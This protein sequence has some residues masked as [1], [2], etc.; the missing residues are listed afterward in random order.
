MASLRPYNAWVA[1][2]Y[3]N[4]SPTPSTLNKRVDIWKRQEI[5]NELG[6]TAYTDFYVRTVWAQI[7][8]QTGSMVFQQ[9]ETILTDV[10]HQ[11]TMRYKSATDIAPGDFLK[12]EGKRYDIKYV[13]NPY[14]S[15]WMIVLYCQE[16]ED[17]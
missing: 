11:V 7:I 8:D 9:T 6:Q 15:N 2:K 5:Q 4:F 1:Q 16:V 3:R 17:T 10:S 13:T 14:E 12:Y